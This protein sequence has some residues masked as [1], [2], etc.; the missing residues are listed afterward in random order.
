MLVL[1]AMSIDY[2]LFRII[3]Q[4]FVIQLFLDIGYGVT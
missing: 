3:Y 4:V 1:L 2:Q